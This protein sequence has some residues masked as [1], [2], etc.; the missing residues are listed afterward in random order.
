MLTILS[1]FFF[2]CKIYVSNN[3]TSPDRKKYKFVQQAVA[4]FTYNRTLSIKNKIKFLIGVI[5]M[6]NSKYSLLELITKCK[7]GDEKSLEELCVKFAPLLK[8]YSYLLHSEDAYDELA[9]TLI[10]CVYTMPIHKA[11]FKMDQY[12]LSYIKSSI[13][14]KFNHLCSFNQKYTGIEYISIDEKSLDIP[15]SNKTDIDNYF[16]LCDLKQLLTKEEYFI[17]YLKYMGYTDLNV[18]KY[19]CV[20]RQAINKRLHKLKIKLQEYFS[21]N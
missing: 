20:T 12:I 4:T 9:L 19:L 17:I 15:V 2:L 1:L 21:Q 8:R 14:N 13:V 16:L 6:E 5:D 3:V 11:N 7:A 10:Q 18:A